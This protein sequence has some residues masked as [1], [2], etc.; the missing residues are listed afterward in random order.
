MEEER[1]DCGI[2]SVMFFERWD[3]TIDVRWAF[4]FSDIENIRVKLANSVFSSPTNLVD[5]ALVN[6]F[7]E[8]DLDPR[9]FK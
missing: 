3:V 8:Q 5:K 9:L 2:F 7:Y 4:D 6:F 1:N